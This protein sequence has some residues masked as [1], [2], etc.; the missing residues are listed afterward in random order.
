MELR[1][2]LD[3]KN[4]EKMRERLNRRRNIEVIDD[5]LALLYWA[6]KET[7]NGRVVVSQDANGENEK[8]VV[9]PGLDDL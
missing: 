4:I 1:I 2:N 5:A 3:R 7:E 8:Q 6:L 9:M